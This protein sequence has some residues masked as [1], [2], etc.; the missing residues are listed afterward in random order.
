MD[1]KLTKRDTELIIEEL[2]VVWDMA[3]EDLQNKKAEKIAKLR[4]KI[5]EQYK[6]QLQ[7]Y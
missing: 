2:Y 7:P 6:E 3:R 1:L 5:V 4:D